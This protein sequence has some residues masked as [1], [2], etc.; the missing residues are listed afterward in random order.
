MAQS[1]RF[2]LIMAFLEI[3]AFHFPEYGDLVLKL[4]REVHS[5]QC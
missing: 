1:N 4:M 3:K 5:S 2:E